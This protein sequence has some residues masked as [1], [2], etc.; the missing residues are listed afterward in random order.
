MAAGGT[1]HHQTLSVLDGMGVGGGPV[2]LMYL[3]DPDGTRV[4]LMSGTPDLS[5]LRGD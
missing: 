1:V 2:K 4:E 5:G 3:T